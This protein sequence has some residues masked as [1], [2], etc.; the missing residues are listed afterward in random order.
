MGETRTVD[1]PTADG[2]MGVYE[3]RPDD[4][5]TRAVFVFQEAF[6]VNDHIEDVTR[7]FADEGFLAVA[8]ALFHRSGSPRMGYDDIQQVYPHMGELT[9]RGIEEDVEQTLEHLRRLGFEDHAIGTVGFCMGG[10]LSLV[11][12]AR[13]PLGAS[14]TFY[15]GGIVEGRFGE[16][17]LME[18]APGLQTPWLGVFGDEDTG[19]P[20]DQVETLRAAAA[21]ALVDTDVVRYPDA[22][23]GFHC[24]ARS[25]F[26]PAPAR[27]A[28]Q[29][30]IAFFG[31][32]LQ[33]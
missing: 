1:L 30:T 22:G 4:T 28:W 11:T 17:P 21:E 15:G 25:A 24:D 31:E 18:L 14:V 33:G 5:P 16:P 7:R 27:D 10:T 13:H 26:R 23:H 12:G 29:R 3:A 20:V 8:P 32:H 9:S 6:G 19:I 2:P